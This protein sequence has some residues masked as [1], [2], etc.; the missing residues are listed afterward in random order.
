MGGASAATNLEP[1][2]AWLERATAS[3]KELGAAEE[4]AV[5]AGV[6]VSTRAE[7]AWV[8][9]CVAIEAKSF[10]KHEAMDISHELLRV[11]GVTLLCATPR[12]A[13][14]GVGVG[15]SVLP[16]ISCV[17]YII[18]QQ[19]EPAAHGSTSYDSFRRTV[20]LFSKL[21]VAPALRRRGIGRALLAA[22]IA[23]ARA[24]RMHAC[25]LNVD[26]ANVSAR[27][28][29]E[30]MGFHIRERLVDYYRP[31]RHALELWLVLEPQLHEPIERSLWEASPEAHLQGN[32]IDANYCAQQ[33][34]HLLALCMTSS[35]A[36][37]S[38]A[39]AD[40]DA[41]TW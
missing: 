36:A 41:P 34:L 13:W 35:Q 8:A 37:A 2:P 16:G 38:E 14:I 12:T 6:H 19:F 27:A 23:N 10:A 5:Q 3:G 31:G 17:G 20:M 21:A 9:Q 39:S 29:Y 1:L 28:L 33:H 7:P 40:C 25:M 18:Q 22:A 4:L 15:A 32:C 24:K 11:P 26:E 30:H